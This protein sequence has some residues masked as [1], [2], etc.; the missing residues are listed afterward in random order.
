MSAAAGLKTLRATS[1]P[2]SWYRCPGGRYPLQFVIWNPAEEQIGRSQVVAIPERDQPDCLTSSLQ[3]LDSRETVEARI[4]THDSAYSALLHYR[5]V[6]GIAWRQAPVA[7][8]NLFRTFGGRYVNRQ[9]LIHYAQKRIERR[10]N[11]IPAIHGCITMEYLLQ[12]LGIG[13]QSFPFGKALFDKPP[14]IGFVRMGRPDQVHRDVGVD[15]NHGLSPLPYP[16]SISA[17]I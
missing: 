17:I 1:Y 8:D 12:H 13:K 16:C 15:E 14:A 10:L 9:N 7:Q 3:A 4:K 6:N 2:P 5:E 11:C